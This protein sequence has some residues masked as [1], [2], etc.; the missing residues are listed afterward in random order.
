MLTKIRTFRR[1]TDGQIL[2]YHAVDGPGDFPTTKAQDLKELQEL[3][4]SDIILT[5]PL[6]KVGRSCLDELGIKSEN[7]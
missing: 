1:R 3:E 5:V 4:V 2:W 6:D 7:D